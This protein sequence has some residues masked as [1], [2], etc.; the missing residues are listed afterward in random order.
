[1][2][3]ELN[4][5]NNIKLN[6]IAFSDTKKDLSFY[7]SP[8]IRGASSS[9]NITEDPNMV[10]LE[11]HADTIDNFVAE[12]SIGKLDFIKCDVEGA[13]F[14]VYKGG[15][16]TIEKYKPVI[17]SEMLR[18]WSAKFNYHPNDIIHF[19]R[20]FGYNCYTAH[21]GKL[22][23]FDLVTEDTLETNYFFLHPVNHKD[24][25]ARVS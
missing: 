21:G 22:E 24:K 12:N 17:F 10:L 6:N 19:F 18:K 5:A 13:E 3:T 14:M 1:M 15:A 9:V 2:N 7:Y 8:V 25:I 20:Q 4:H 16:A 11:C 23:A